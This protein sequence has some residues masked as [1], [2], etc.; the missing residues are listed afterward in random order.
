MR[1]AQYASTQ[2]CGMDWRVRVDI[3]ECAK[4]YACAWMRMAR[5]IMQHIIY[6]NTRWRKVLCGDIIRAGIKEQGKGGAWFEG[7]QFI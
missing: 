2:E 7:L 1:G 3:N 4:Q 5:R 6:M